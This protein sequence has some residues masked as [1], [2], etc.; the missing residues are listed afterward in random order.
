M[1]KLLFVSI[2]VLFVFNACDEIPSEVVDS[3]DPDF[4]VLAVNAPTEFINTS[5]DSVLT[6]SIS[7][8]NTSTI[9]A[10]WF[11]IV[12][13]DGS[14]TLKQRV[15]MT[16]D[17]NSTNGDNKA[18]DGIYTGKTILGSSVAG[19]TYV[20]DYYAENNVRAGSDK[21]QLVSS[22]TLQ[23]ISSTENVAPVLSEL[24]APDSV[25]VQ[26]PKSLILLQVKATDENGL[27]DIENVSFVVISPDAT[28]SNP[29]KMLDDGKTEN[30]DNTAGDGIYSRIIEVTPSNTKGDYT[31]KFTAE[32]RS[33]ALSNTITHTITIK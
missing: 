17:G 1:K 25:E 20:I 8:E 24:T 2:L 12:T 27:V 3:A 32:D 14:A 23:F 7:F 18:G 29:I 21:V 10:V 4:R 19:G 30:G 28:T 5:T 11:N 31:F 26:D 16:D 13:E 9:S 22:H 15:A 6:T 33:G